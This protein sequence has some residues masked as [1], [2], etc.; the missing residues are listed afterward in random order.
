VEIVKTHGP[1]RFSKTQREEAKA[2]KTTAKILFISFPI[3]RIIDIPVLHSDITA[4]ERTGFKLVNLDLAMSCQTF[5]TPREILIRTTQPVKE[6][7]SQLFDVRRAQITF[8]S[9]R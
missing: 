5:S 8:L 6:Y 7:I 2:N 9:F 3:L 1:W 4:S